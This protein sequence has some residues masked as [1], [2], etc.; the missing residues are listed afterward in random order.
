MLKGPLTITDQINMYMGAGWTGYGNPPGRLAYENRKV[1]RKFYTRNEFNWW[2]T[3]QRV[4]WDVEMAHA[5][6]VHHLYDIGPIRFAWINHYCTSVIGDDA[7][8]YRIRGELRRFNYVGDAT[9]IRGVVTSKADATPLGPRVD[10]A[11]TGTNQRGEVNI[12]G[13]A[14]VLLASRRYGPVELPP[15]PPAPFIPEAT[16]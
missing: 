3:I 1:L 11:L 5:V 16:S 6:G 9:W 12:N 13:T 8:L 15:A 14:T 2:D 4:H 10:I 7:W